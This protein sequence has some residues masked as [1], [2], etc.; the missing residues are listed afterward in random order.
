[1]E[2]RLQ[3]SPVELAT[4]KSVSTARALALILLVS[5]A[6]FAFLSW[7]IWFKT[8]AENRSA[9]VSQLPAVNAGLNTLSTV[10][11]VSGFVAVKRGHV[12]RHM[13]LMFAALASSA[14]F[15][16]GYVVYHH[17]HGDT[18]FIGTGPVRPVYFFVLIS[19]VVLSLV[20]LP[21]VL[22][23]FFTA[24]AGRMSAHRKLS[25][26]T[27]PVWLYVSVTGV[28]VFLMLRFLS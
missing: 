4:L 27:F 15:L 3:Y 6:A 23:S 25:K 19:H 10:F 5:A 17:F 20:A 8:A 16:V 22:L 2:T 1:M 7:V 12:R 11:L 13:R 26:Y 28:V 14:L 21:M 24:L 18:K 9:F